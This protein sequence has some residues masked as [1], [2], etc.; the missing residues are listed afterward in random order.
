VS[1]FEIALIYV[2]LGDTSRAFEWLERAYL[3]RSDLLVYLKV[4]PRLDPIRSDRRFKDLVARVGI[5]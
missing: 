4:D 1:P 3:E 2:G 5:P